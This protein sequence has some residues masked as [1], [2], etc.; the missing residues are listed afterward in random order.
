MRCTHTPFIVLKNRYN[1]IVR[2]TTLHNYAGVFED[3]VFVPITSDAKAKLHYIC[4]M[5]NYVLIKHYADFRIDHV[6]KV[7]REMLE[8][9]FRDYATEQLPNGEFRGEQSVEKCVHA[10]TAFFRKLR[11]RFGGHVLL[12]EEDLVSERTVY[13]KYGKPH[14]KK[15]PA[16]QVRGIP[17]RGAK[18]RDIPTK[19]FKILLSLAFHYAPDIAFALC[20]QSFAGLRAGEVCN[21]RQEGSPMG[22]GLVFTRMEG[23]ITKIE[24]DLL[25][26]L[27]MR[28]DGVICGKIKKER[29]QCVYPPFVEAFAAAYEHHR[30]FLAARRFEQKYKPMFINSR[31]MALTYDSYSQRFAELV[32]NH[33]RAVLL[34][35]DDPELRICGQLLYENGLTA[36]ALRHWFSTQLVLRGEDISQIQFWRGDKNPESAFTYLQ[37]KGDLVREL[38]SANEYLAEILMEQGAAR[39]DDI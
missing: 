1:V 30:K 17:K 20:C 19:A 8:R 26:E 23:R 22:N 27:P 31:G 38:E 32:D 35:C 24:I 12:K 34:E 33:F 7:S 36:H 9:F 15:I 11:R 14:K 13:N 28:S 2:F 16:F 18:L 4:M 25:R 29:I 5:L 39:I 37:D 3:K 21:V 10:V 6:F